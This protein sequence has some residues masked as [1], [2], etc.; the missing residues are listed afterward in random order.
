MSLV[1]KVD[2]AAKVGYDGIEP[3]VGEVEDYVEQGGSLD[4]LK[5]RISDKGLSVPDAMG[6]IE[7]IVDDDDLRA[8]GFEKAKRNMEMV[9]QIGA[10]R[11]AAPPCGVK[12]GESVDLLRAAERYRELLELGDTCDVIPMVE[13]WWMSPALYRLGQAV[14]IAIESGHPKACVLADVFHIYRGGG[15]LDSLRLL[16]PDILGMMHMNDY[17]ADPPMNEINDGH[18]VHAGDGVAPLVQ[19]FRD[20]HDIGFHGMISLEVFKYKQQD[21]LEVAQTGL[22]KMREIADMAMDTFSR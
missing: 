21:A 10:E 4:D 9:R 20:L 8:K 5:K 7:W 14:M 16:G 1:E 15:R 3:W 6:F 13:F 11:L 22:L 18:R 2:V 12:E 19:V 17:P